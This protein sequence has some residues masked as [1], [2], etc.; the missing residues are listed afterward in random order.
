[1][2]EQSQRSNRRG[3]R[4][5]STSGGR[6]N[7]Q[8][9]SKHATRAVATAYSLAQEITK[10]L[11]SG[12]L[13]PLVDLG[14][15]SRNGS[16]RSR[17]PRARGGTAIGVR[18][19]AGQSRAATAEQAHDLLDSVVGLLQVG[20]NVFE[21][22]VRTFLDMYGESNRDAG[23]LSDEPEVSESE[24]LVARDVP[25]GRIS[26]VEMAVDNMTDDPLPDPELY[27]TGLWGRHDHIPPDK[28]KFEPRDIALAPQQSIT[29]T[30]SVDV[31]STIRPGLY[32][33]I[34]QSAHMEDVRA[35][36][37]VQVI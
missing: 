34:V 9:A 15:S 13:S 10:G 16:T 19:T 29:V 32:V 2:S 22:S 20:V 1:M 27:S 18:S 17:R 25:R 8:D 7:I 24:T 23:G 37:E 36:L 26:T 14:R 21:D 28:L 12:Q 4:A 5:K 30:I 11:T 33:G 35:I 3:A 31:P 6:D